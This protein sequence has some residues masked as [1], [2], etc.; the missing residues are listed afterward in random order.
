MGQDLKIVLKWT[1]W[2]RVQDQGSWPETGHFFKLLTEEVSAS[3]ACLMVVPVAAA[4]RGATA[5]MAS[6]SLSGFL[7]DAWNRSWWHGFRPVR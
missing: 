6:T 3:H 4:F 5:D 2:S 7:L 1:G